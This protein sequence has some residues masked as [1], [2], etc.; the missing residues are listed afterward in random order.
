MV[1][2]ARR[3]LNPVQEECQVVWWKLFNAVDA[4][5]WRNILSLVELLFCLPM[6]NGRVERI[7]SQL[8]LI[9]TERHT[10][11]GIDKLDSWLRIAADA[12]FKWDASGA[13]QRWWGDKKCRKVKDT[14]APPK[15]KEKA[16]EDD[17]DSDHKDLHTI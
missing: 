5:K 12:L 16:S 15:R 10:C 4:K 14:Q 13:V 1:D 8:K 17:S 11:L 6:A 2:Y 9:K 7:F 3:Y